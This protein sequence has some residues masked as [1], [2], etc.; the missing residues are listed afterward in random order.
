MNNFIWYNIDKTDYLA[1]YGVKGMKWGKRTSRYATDPNEPDIK[2]YYGKDGKVH[3]FINKAKINPSK[4][5]QPSDMKDYN[6]TFYDKEGNKHVYYNPTDE[7]GNPDK[8]KIEEHVTPE[9]TVR[10]EKLDLDL[11]KAKNPIDIGK[12]YVDF[13]LTSVNKFITSIFKNFK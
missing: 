4:Y 1:H 12:A 11:K 7:F 9:E 8:T 3:T 13:A 6:T 5:P 10:K 2:Y